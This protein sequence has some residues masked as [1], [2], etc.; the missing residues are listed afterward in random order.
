[1]FEFKPWWDCPSCGAAKSFGVLFVGRD[2]YVRRCSKCRHSVRF[3]LPELRKRVFYLDQ[4]AI[5]LMA[6]ALLRGQDDDWLRLFEKLDVLVRAQLVI[7]P[8]SD[9]H[10]I[11]SVVSKLHVSL[12]R[13]YAHF[14]GGVALFPTHS[15]KCYQF[16]TAFEKHLGG[17]QGDPFEFDPGCIVMSGHIHGWLEHFTFLPNLQLTQDDL[18]RIRI[19]RDRVSMALTAVFHRW[20]QEKQ[21]FE[22]Y[23]VEEA[24]S[25]GPALLRACALHIQRL[26]KGCADDS[27]DT[28]MLLYPHPAWDLFSELL[29]CMPEEFGDDAKRFSTVVEFLM[30]DQMREIPYVRISS[31]IYAALAKQANHGQKREPTR[32]LRNDI[33]AIS[34]YLPYLDAVFVDNEMRNIL[35]SGDVRRI[36]HYPARVFSGSNLSEALDFLDATLRAAP[37]THL[38]KVEEV[39]GEGWNTPFDSILG[40]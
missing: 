1:M 21:T 27:L 28:R 38:A 16:R 37:P 30:S 22:R 31:A 3:E 35:E 20:Q 26:Q 13:L 34:A 14:A 40:L 15:I 36:L 24:N 7:C 18:E 5:S 2:C 19:D 25:H 33:D 23:F 39:Y 10:L 29:R 12:K 6:K 32:G 11:E 4:C 9:V 17:Q 8:E